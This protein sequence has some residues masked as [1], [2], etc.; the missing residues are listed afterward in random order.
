M[1]TSST[2]LQTCKFDQLAQP[3]VVGER[4]GLLELEPVPGG[5][6]LHGDLTHSDEDVQPQADLVPI[7]T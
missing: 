2:K 4:I 6:Q 7:I 3:V 5:E 1:R